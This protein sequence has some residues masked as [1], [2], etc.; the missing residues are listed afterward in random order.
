MVVDRTAK[1]KQEI[2]LNVETKAFLCVG[3]FRE[4]VKRVILTFGGTF[5]GT[6]YDHEQE[7][8]AH[9]SSMADNEMDESGYFEKLGAKTEKYLERFFTTWG[10]YCASNPW[11]ILL[12]GK[13]LVTLL[14]FTDLTLT[15]TNQV[16]FSSLHLASVCSGF[17]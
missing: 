3:K 17:T 13:I 12:M 16:S 7:L 8:R 14:K 15:F 9:P 11:K 2:S 5:A 10:T 1:K 6:S 4:L